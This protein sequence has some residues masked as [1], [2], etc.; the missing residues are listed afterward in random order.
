LPELTIPLATNCLPTWSVIARLTA[1]AFAAR[2]PAERTPCSWRMGGLS[3]SRRGD[4]SR[5]QSGAKGPF[6]HERQRVHAVNGE[7]GFQPDDRRVGRVDGAR[8]CASGEERV[9]G[10]RAGRDLLP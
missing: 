2:E 5:E 7:Q 8:C 1:I 10:A 4:L 6:G 3:R 9:F